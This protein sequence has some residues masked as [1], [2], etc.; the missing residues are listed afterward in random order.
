LCCLKD[1]NVSDKPRDDIVRKYFNIY[2]VPFV[3]RKTTKILTIFLTVCL[4]IIGIFSSI[5]LLRGLNQNVSLVE[6]SDLF[7]YFNT[8]YDYGNAGPPGYVIFNNVNY[9]DPLNLEKMELIN[10][11]LAGLNNTIQSPIYSWVTPFKNFIAGGVWS[12]SCD[13]KLASILPFDD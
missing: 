2:V 6:G 11:E 1:E 13:S 9:S 12:D 8:L 5:K 10:A 4:V 7:D 3:F